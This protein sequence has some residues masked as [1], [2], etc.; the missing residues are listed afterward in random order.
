MGNGVCAGKQ[1]TSQ[2]LAERQQCTLF[3]LLPHNMFWRK[4]KTYNDPVALFFPEFIISPQLPFFSP[5][6]PQR[7]PVMRKEAVESLACTRAEE[8]GWQAM[9]LAAVLSHVRLRRHN[10]NC[11]HKATHHKNHVVAGVLPALLGWRIKYIYVA[12]S[13]NVLTGLKTC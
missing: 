10:M 5:H 9:N 13:K 3:R 6:F 4:Q 8:T 2:A 1:T 11:A 12:V 7:K